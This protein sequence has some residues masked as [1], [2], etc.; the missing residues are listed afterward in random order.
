MDTRHVQT[1]S[2]FFVSFVDLLFLSPSLFQSTFHTQR[3]TFDI[4]IVPLRVTE[5]V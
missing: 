4:V 5:L 2:K 3:R 1:L